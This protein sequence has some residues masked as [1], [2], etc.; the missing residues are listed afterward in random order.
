MV[1]FFLPFACWFVF[2]SV[3]LEMLGREVL[4]VC[5]SAVKFLGF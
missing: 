2:E 1:D 3:F 5:V 4:N